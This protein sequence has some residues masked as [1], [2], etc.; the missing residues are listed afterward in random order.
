MW[1]VGGQ[2]VGT[3]A[4]L[5]ARVLSVG[6]G[7]D[8]MAAEINGALATGTVQSAVD[9][10]GAS[11]FR[12]AQQVLEA[13]DEMSKGG[14]QDLLRQTMESPRREE[15]LEFLATAV[16][17][18]ARS[19]DPDRLKL[20]AQVWVAGA[21]GRIAIDMMEVWL[22]LANQLT[23][24][25]IHLLQCF[26]GYESAMGLQYS[27]EEAPENKLSK[28]GLADVWH[29]LGGRL[30]SLGLATSANGRS[31]ALT[32]FGMRFMAFLEEHAARTSKIDGD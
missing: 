2:L 4:G 22:D 19:P 21:E 16:E 25:H 12:R 7:L 6:V 28:S 20:L 1:T 14:L 5:A 15:V 26:D 27:L 8:P 10:M 18:G 17:M 30:V 9:V 24:Q 32:A 23:A 3:W 13:A 11:R 29:L 31:Y